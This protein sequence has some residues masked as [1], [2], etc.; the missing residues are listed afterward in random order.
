M[1]VEGYFVGVIDVLGEVYF[2]LPDSLAMIQ[3]AL[4]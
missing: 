4:K 3:G 2:E 1:T